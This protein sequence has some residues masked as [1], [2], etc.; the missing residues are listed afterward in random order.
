MGWEAQHDL[1]TPSAKREEEDFSPS[2]LS[3]ASLPQA[4]HIS[5]RAENQS[6]L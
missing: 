2:T 3:Y 5:D 1:L 4:Y 6:Y